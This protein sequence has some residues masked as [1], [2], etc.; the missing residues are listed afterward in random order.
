MII[1]IIIISMATILSLI[2]VFSN[3]KYIPLSPETN[4]TITLETTSDEWCGDVYMEYRG[5]LGINR[6]GEVVYQTDSITRL[7][8]GRADQFSIVNVTTET[9]RAKDIRIVIDWCDVDARSLIG[10][11]FSRLPPY[12][13]EI[14]VV[15]LDNPPMETNEIE[16]VI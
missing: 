8:L 6:F 3:T 1:I 7:P 5:Y 13:S 4:Y 16:T 15:N 11:S 14:N 9:P 12:I 10:P 2:F